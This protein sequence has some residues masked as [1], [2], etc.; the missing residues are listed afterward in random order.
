MTIQVDEIHTTSAYVIDSENKKTQRLF[1]VY[2]D[3]GNSIKVADVPGISSLPSIGDQHPDVPELY[4][5]SLSINKPNDG[6]GHVVVV[7]IA[8]ENEFIE[9]VEEAFV[10]FS[11]KVSSIFLDAFRVGASLPNN[12][13]FPPDVD[14]AGTKIDMAGSPVS[15]QATQQTLET[16]FNVESVP[17][18]AS[19][20]AATGKRNSGTYLGFAPGTLLYLG[21][22]V[23]RVG[24]NLYQRRDSFVY[25][26]F[27]HCRQVIGEIDM[28]GRAVLD[29]NQRAATVYWRQPFSGT[30]NFGNLGIPL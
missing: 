28:D 2:D 4:A 6:D 25:D 19:L 30:F 20:F 5:Q 15:V 27:A 18:F 16:T 13:N 17:N 9:G 22:T 12:F 23:D 3:T 8:Y 10:R 29:E 21:P 7:D 24:A 14:I 26:S 1:R 11:T